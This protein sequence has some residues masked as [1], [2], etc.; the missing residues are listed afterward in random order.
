MYSSGKSAQ[1]DMMAALRLSF[2][3]MKGYFFL[4]H[5]LSSAQTCL[6]GLRL[7]QLA[8]QLSTLIPVL[9]RYYLVAAEA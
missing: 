8:G 4:I 9:S 7:G 3:P 6:I 5:L 2:D 1:V